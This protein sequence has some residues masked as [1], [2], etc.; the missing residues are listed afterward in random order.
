MGIRSLD[1]KSV[2]PK[3]KGE[4]CPLHVDLAGVL[5]QLKDTLPLSSQ[6]IQGPKDL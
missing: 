3:G 2:A 6:C 4:P 5:I 1:R